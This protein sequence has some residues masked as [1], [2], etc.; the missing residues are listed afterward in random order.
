VD[1]RVAE[2]GFGVVYRGYH[3]GLAAPIAVKIL[4]R[5]SS[6]DADAWADLVAQFLDE[7]KTIARLRHPA[8]VNVMDRRC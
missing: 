7:A 2:G 3:L 8:V 4:K 1:S 5:P 6:V